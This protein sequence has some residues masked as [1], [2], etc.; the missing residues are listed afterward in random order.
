M[1]TQVAN[2]YIAADDHA[3]APAAVRT[4]QRGTHHLRVADA[5]KAARQ[6]QQKCSSSQ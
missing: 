3:L 5:L 1:L 6:Q 2:A 4:L